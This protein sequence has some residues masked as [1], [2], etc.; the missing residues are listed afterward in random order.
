MPKPKQ[1]TRANAEIHQFDG[2]TVDEDG[3]I[4]LGFYYRFL[5]THDIPISL[6]MGPYASASE[7]EAACHREYNLSM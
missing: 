3:E 1:Q 4:M 6:L 2:S 5:D 7:A